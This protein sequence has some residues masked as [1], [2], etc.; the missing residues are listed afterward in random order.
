MR[1][2]NGL[3][4]VLLA[5][6]LSVAP[7]RADDPPASAGR[8]ALGVAVDGAVAGLERSIPFGRSFRI[9]IAGVVGPGESQTALGAFVADRAEAHLVGRASR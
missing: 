2:G 6:A 9:G 4:F 3:L 8:D 1:T 7:A 5:G